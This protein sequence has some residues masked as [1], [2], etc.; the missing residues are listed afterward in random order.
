MPEH[1]LEKLLGAFASD[2]LTPDEK[3]RLYH[4]AL[5]DQHLFNALAD[6]QALK[7]LLTDPAVR[8]RLLQALQQTNPSGAGG[9]RSWIDWFRRPANLAWAGGFTTVLLAVVLGTK[10]YQDSL[11]Q[12]A[13][14]LAAE[15][16]TPTAPPSRACRARPSSRSDS[17]RGAS[18]RS[19]NGCRDAG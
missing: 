3:Q 18:A 16:I 1:E 9:S 15:E 11:K 5:Q 2:T 12:A 19:T 13:P 10:L 14:S 6:E 4:A 17:S 7:E 8:R